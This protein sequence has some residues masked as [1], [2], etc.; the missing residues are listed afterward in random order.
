[1]M[2]REIGNAVRK[3]KN[4]RD[5]ARRLATD[6]IAELGKKS[7]DLS[8]RIDH[9]MEYFT[10][11]PRNLD[12]A[13]IVPKIEH[14]V[15]V[16]D[17]RYKNEIKILA[18]EA[19]EVQSSNIEGVLEIA[20]GLNNVYKIV[21]HFYLLGK[22]TMSIYVIMQVQMQLPLI[23][24]MAEAF[25][26]SGKAFADGQPIGDG[27]GALVA[28]KMMYGNE[29][30]EIAKNTVVSQIDVEGRKVFMIKAQGPGADPGKPSEAINKL[31]NENAGRVAMV[32]MVDAA[33]KLEGEESGSPSQQRQP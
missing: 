12:P 27:A 1:M 33:G 3:L 24:Q 21:N 22:K 28:A 18:P 7:G 17:Q 4:M 29:I 13:G 8:P 32:I 11:M 23:M 5:D 6:T 10:L 25:S 14:L 30:R 15:D 9:L 16:R 2:L 31:L 20:L 19:D 26:L